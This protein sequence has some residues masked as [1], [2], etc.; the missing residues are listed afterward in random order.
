MTVEDKVKDVI[1]GLL[2]DDPQDHRLSP[3]VLK[4]VLQELVVY[5]ITTSM[6]S[7]ELELIQDTLKLHSSV[8]RD[9]PRLLSAQSW[10]QWLVTQYIE[11][12]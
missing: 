5:S 4:Q 8:R 7:A 6:N 3:C 10:I 2:I 1:E 9:D 11:G 12:P